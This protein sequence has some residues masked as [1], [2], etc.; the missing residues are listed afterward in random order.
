[1]KEYSGTEISL[2]SS[3]L[4][5]MIMQQRVS[6]CKIPGCLIAL[7]HSLDTWPIS[8]PLCLIYGSF[9]RVLH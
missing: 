7:I 8:K 2:K 6:C 9:I 4:L 5:E 3:L 1:M